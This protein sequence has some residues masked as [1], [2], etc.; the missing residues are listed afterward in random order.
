MS[1]AL[2]KRSPGSLA[3][4]RST[5][6]TRPGSRSG[7]GLGKREYVVGFDGPHHGVGVSA[8]NGLLPLRAS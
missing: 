3:I 7:Q 4:A 6:A 5:V 8:S 2:A 1:E